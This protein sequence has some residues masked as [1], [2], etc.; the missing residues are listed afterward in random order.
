MLTAI[1]L[2]PQLFLL[3]VLIVN[4]GSYKQ[5]HPPQA[6]WCSHPTDVFKSALKFGTFSAVMVTYTASALLHV[7][8]MWNFL[9]K[10]LSLI[11]CAAARLF[12]VNCFDCDSCVWQG[13]S[14]HLGAV[15]ISL[16]FITYIEHGESQPNVLFSTLEPFHLEKVLSFAVMVNCSRYST[17]VLFTAVLVI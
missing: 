17:L 9:Q 13:L 7:S 15:L 10:Q 12:K 1:A 8:A 2:W 6:S 11:L 14:F 16:G 4:K 3:F 5:N